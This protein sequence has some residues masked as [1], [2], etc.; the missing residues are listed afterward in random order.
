[1]VIS[2]P[3][4]LTRVELIAS[5]R[6]APAPK[7]RRIFIVTSP[8]CCTRRLPGDVNVLLWCTAPPS[9]LTAKPF[10]H[11]RSTDA[12]I[13]NPPRPSTCSDSDLK[14]TRNDIRTPAVGGL[15]NPL[16]YCAR[17]LHDKILHRPKAG[18]NPGNMRGFVPIRPDHRSEEHTS[19]LQSR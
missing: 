17:T 16:I 9:R 15:R 2:L 4:A 14:A 7:S 10:D 13:I 11:Q 12:L 18:G 19:E 5:A 8:K 6:T 1:M 3:A